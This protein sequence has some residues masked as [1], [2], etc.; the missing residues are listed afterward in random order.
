[1]ARLRDDESRMLA[2]GGSHPEL[3]TCIIRGL[4]LTAVTVLDRERTVIARG[5]GGTGWW[6]ST[7]GT[8]AEV[9]TLDDFEYVGSLST[10]PDELWASYTAQLRAWAE[11]G[12]ELTWIDA[13]SFALLHDGRRPLPLPS[14]PYP[15]PDPATA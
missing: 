3:L 15:D 6:I 9:T 4:R 12:T 11:A 14:T 8:E 1:M 10:M 5:H 13:T 2:H 7:T